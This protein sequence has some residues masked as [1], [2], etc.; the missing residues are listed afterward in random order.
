MQSGYREFDRVLPPT[1]RARILL[2]AGDVTARLTLTAVLEKGGYCV[3][4][5]ATPAEALD[6]L[7]S[8]EF[9]LVLCG[10]MDTGSSD[11]L[12]S[13]IRFAKTLEYRPAT[14]FLTASQLQPSGSNAGEDLFVEPVDVPTL[15]MT[16]ADLIGSRA[17]SRARTAARRAHVAEALSA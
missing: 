2:V 10:L 15:L 8:K 12:R 9:A 11:A 7:E 17:A 14:A 4:Q 3:E 5:A 6:L 13:V 1:A 16:V